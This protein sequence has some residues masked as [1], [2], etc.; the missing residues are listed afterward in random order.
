M[1]SVDKRDEINHIVRKRAK[2][3]KKGNL[4]L[5]FFSGSKKKLNKCFNK[6]EISNIKATKSTGGILKLAKFKSKPISG[7]KKAVK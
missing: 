2:A 1:G 6:K 7:N 5:I 4:N 3:N